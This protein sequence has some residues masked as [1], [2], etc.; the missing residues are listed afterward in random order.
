MSLVINTSIGALSA[1]RSLATS[2]DGATAALIVIDRALARTSDAQSD[3]CVKHNR[4]EYTVSNLMN[5]S[6]NST[7]ARSRIEDADFAVESARLTKAPWR[8][9]LRESVLASCSKRGG[10]LSVA[11]SPTKA[12]TK[13]VW[14]LVGVS[15]LKQSLPP[16][17]AT[18]ETHKKPLLKFF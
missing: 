18:V 15:A 10:V 17:L 12:Q 3:Y 6:T 5:V 8:A 11:F 9:R 13:G 7:T 1:Q 2:S 16:Q 14:K 4:L